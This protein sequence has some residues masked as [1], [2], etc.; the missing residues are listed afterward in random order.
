MEAASAGFEPQLSA[1]TAPPQGR[2]REE[3]QD[4]SRLGL[5]AE[6]VHPSSVK[7][8]YSAPK[9]MR[10]IGLVSSPLS[11]PSWESL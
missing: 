9:G 4:G 10:D 7:W 6:S 2:L 3:V 11:S 1:A 5:G 8:E